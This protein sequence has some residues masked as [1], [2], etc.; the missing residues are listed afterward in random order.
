VN[1]SFRNTATVRPA[2]MSRLTPVLACLFT[3][4]GLPV[5]AAVSFPD[6]PMQTNNG[7]PPNI[8]FILD[9][10]G[11]MAWRYMYN[12]DV[13]ALFNGATQVSTQTGNNT[14]SDATNGPAA[15]TLAAMYDQNYV[16]NTIYY[17]PSTTYRGW[18]RADGSIMPDIPYT[19]VLNSNTHVTGG[20]TANLDNV[21][22][23][24][25]TPT[26]TNTNLSDARQYIRH[27]IHQTGATISG[28]GSLFVSS[29]RWDATINNFANPNATTAVLCDRNFAT[30]TWPGGITRTIQQEK[31][32]FANW[33][34]YHRTRSK[35][36]KAGASYAF[37]DESVFNADN[38]YRVGFTTIWQRSEFRIPVGTNNGVFTGTNRTTWFDR[39]FDAT[40][41]STTPLI[42]A[43]SRAGAYFSEP[44][45]GGPWGP[46]ATASQY[47]CRQN[48]TILTT[49]GYWNNTSGA[50]T[51]GNVDNTG[52]STIVRP[53]TPGDEGDSFTYSA[54]NPWRDGW[55]NTLADVAMYY[56]VRDLR[57]DLDNKVPKSISNPAFWQHMVTFGISIG[58]KGTLDPKSKSD[59]DAL[60]N[61][62]KVWP[63]PNDN[64]DLERIDDLY[65]A[66][67]NGRGAFVA[68]GNPTEFSE[69][70]GSALRAISARRGSGSNATISGTS[71]SA[72]GKVF[73]A[74]YFASKWYGELQA[75]SVSSS[76][77]DTSTPL[78]TASIPAFTTRKILTH[79][80]TAGA[81][82]PTAA[83]TAVLTPDIADYL[84][85]DRSK[86]LPDTSPSTGRIYRQRTSLL[87][88]IVDSSPTYVKASD[89][90]ETV[91]V[92]ANDG[93][94][95]AF[96]ANTGLE[97][98]AYV[99]RG[100]DLDELKGFSEPNFGHT[101]FVDGPIITSTERELASKTVLVGTLG[102]GGKGL[103][104]L[105]V[106]DPTA[107]VATKVL[108]D[109][110]GAGDN[111]MGQILSKPLIA[112]LND[113]STALIVSNGMNSSSE[114]AVLYVFDLQTGA[115]ITRINAGGSNNGLS[116]PRGWDDDGNGT[117]DYIYAGDFQGY[118]WKFDLNDSNPS[119]WEVADGR[120]LYVPAAPGTQPITGGV[121]IGVDPGTDK[122]W[123]FFGTGR[124]LTTSDISDTSRQTWH[125]VIDDP[126]ATASVTRATMTAR[127]IPFTATN[128]RAFEPHSALPPT[129]KGWY[130]NLDLPSNALEGERM[131]GDQ[132]IIKNALIAASIIPLTSSNPCR[133]GRGYINAIDAFTGTS[134]TTSLFDANSD[135][136]FDGDDT[137]GGGSA[138]VGSID[139]GVGMVTDP[140]LM[141]RLLV[142]GGS[143]ATLGSTPLDPALYGGRISWLEVIR[144]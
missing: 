6:V 36:A 29:C 57:T 22:T 106:T 21:V 102:R 33:F 97:R 136:V 85:G 140:A 7:V 132:Q 17:N 65:H 113:G 76:G 82:F 68:A 133:P 86:E 30:F 1:T 96:D 62:T 38:E 98:F 99:P 55:S 112:K 43:L 74:K 70:I 23:T 125:G 101:F 109:K 42:P 94:M 34:S 35:I 50:L 110:D 63:N 58:L 67:V 128:S 126:A 59:T 134:L 107:F 103:Y 40:A 15:T 111:D 8:W 143:L 93:M 54:A 72:G 118:V 39:L 138:A 25:Y 81:T 26:T 144:R 44:G 2:R 114:D 16:T 11:S 84:R 79:N 51:P 32:N 78:W 28:G 14:G 120:P 47:E 66:S 83:Q 13:T 116:A 80:G 91:Y 64:E 108:W 137:L 19:A 117:V 71:T 130:V 127:D 75:Y 73:Q 129:S 100:L 90:T 89:G 31:D 142:A 77:V 87:G 52:G 124:L 105:D 60:E 18:Q 121:T 24:F 12:P 5:H 119:N 20:T 41:S 92:G 10:S 69:G 27:R 141:D 131:V 48:F 122:R 139:L 56:W 49:D 123:V 95:H 115:E 3:V 9:D 46:Q 53:P 61:G 4:L 104:A 37:N 45:A 135:G 88:T